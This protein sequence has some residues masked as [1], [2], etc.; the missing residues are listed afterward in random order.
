MTTLAALLVSAR[1]PRTVTSI[2]AASGLSRRTIN[3]YERGQVPTLM[4]L[5]KLAD[6]LGL[7]LA[8]RREVLAAHVA[9]TTAAVRS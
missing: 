9:A 7:S 8:A 3:L 5:V 2:A 4:S 6:A 1:G